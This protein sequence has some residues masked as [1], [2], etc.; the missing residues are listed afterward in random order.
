MRCADSD[1]G[2]LDSGEL[3]KILVAVS[4]IGVPGGMGS[5]NESVGLDSDDIFESARGCDAENDRSAAGGAA[6]VISF[7]SS[8]RPLISSR[9]ASCARRE[10]ASSSRIPESV[11][12]MLR[13]P[14]GR[15][16]PRATVRGSGMRLA[17][18]G[19]AEAPRLQ[20]RAGER[21]SGRLGMATSTE[22]TASGITIKM[23]R[24]GTSDIYPQ[25]SQ[26]LAVHYDA[27]LPN[28]K[29]WDSS[30][31]RGVPLRFRM[32][33]GQVIPGLNDA[34][35]QLSMGMR[36]RVTIP[37][38]QAYGERGFPGLVP[39]NSTVEFDLELLE[40]V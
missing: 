2:G 12:S 3:R 33:A 31:K 8:R 1:A 35:S 9:S 13:G 14:A 26:S 39:P 22:R 20:Q 18:G 37:A 7:N 32:G 38:D 34:V 17:D 25:V 5:G 15:V 19:A 4:Q 16:E 36:A 6:T 24:A 23:L 27:F 40:I 11:S 10:A 30:R 21:A 29:M 28:G